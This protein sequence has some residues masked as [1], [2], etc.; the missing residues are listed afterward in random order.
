MNIGM[1]VYENLGSGKVTGFWRLTLLSMTSYALIR[2]VATNSNAF[3][4][5]VA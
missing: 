2:S 3:G 4:S 5:E 1:S